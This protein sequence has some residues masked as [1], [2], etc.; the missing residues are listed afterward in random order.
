L[1]VGYVFERLNYSI[2]VSY[3]LN[4]YKGSA[5]VGCVHDGW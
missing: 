3:V 5:D 4:R 2:D 1:N